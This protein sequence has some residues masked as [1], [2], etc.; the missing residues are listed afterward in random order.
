MLW[1]RTEPAADALV[2]GMMPDFGFGQA[3]SDYDVTTQLATSSR[4]IC[5][6]RCLS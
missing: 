1:L 2:K 3:A 4:R 5:H 6:S